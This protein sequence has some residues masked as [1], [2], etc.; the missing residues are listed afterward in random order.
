MAKNMDLAFSDTS[1]DT[2]RRRLA[3]LRIRATL[4]AARLKNMWLIYR[5]SPLAM[6]GLILI[7]LFGVLA[8]LH[9]ILMATVWPSGIYDPQ[10]GYDGMVMHPDGPSS[11]HLL[12]TDGLGRDVLSQL[13][14]ATTPTFVLGITAALSTAVSGTLIGGLAG[15][16][17]GRVDALLSRVSDTFLLL[18]APILMVIVGTRFR[19]LGPLQLGLIYGLF[20]GIGNTAI[21]MRSLAMKL[22]V[23]PFIEVSKI[24]GGG[25]FYILLRHIIPHLLPMA[26]LQTMVA[27]TGAVVADGFISFFGFTRGISNWGTMIYNA[28]TYG[29]SL[30]IIEPL[31]NALLPPSMALSLF[32]LAFYLTSRGM[33]RVADP[34]LR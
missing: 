9:P 2:L 8:V 28:L 33:H 3:R 14:A 31:W 25:S 12:G 17:R 15:Y 16:Y 27:V 10:V 11:A 30:G 24:S 1:E 6:I 34:R 21:V 22:R 5:Q 13:L 32:G 4:T 19:D 26:A 7:G 20:A 23:L 29:Q 18:P